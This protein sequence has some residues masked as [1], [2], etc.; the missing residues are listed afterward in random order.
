MFWILLAPSIFPN[1]DYKN[2]FDVYMAVH[3]LTLHTVP[4]ISSTINIAL[5]DMVLLKQDTKWM[6]WLGIFYIFANGMGTIYNGK[7]IYP[8]VDW[9]NIPQTIFIFVL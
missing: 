2:P 3:M 7:P 4:I 8:I 6:F 5:T 9:V 1:L